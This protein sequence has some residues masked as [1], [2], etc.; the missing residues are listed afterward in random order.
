MTTSSVTCLA[1]DY[2]HLPLCD[3]HCGDCGELLPVPDDICPFCS[4]CLDR[5]AEHR[6][7]AM[8]DHRMITD[9]DYCPTCE[10][11]HDPEHDVC[12][13]DR[14]ALYNDL[15]RAVGSLTT[16][17]GQLPGNSERA[18]LF[19]LAQQRL[20]QLHHL[21]VMDQLFAEMRERS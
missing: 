19:A 3:R 8:E 6:M 21:D 20:G 13:N 1:C 15:I 4:D 17:V 14:G 7:T 2:G 9:P 5:C 11:T 12:E 18:L 10:V 16:P